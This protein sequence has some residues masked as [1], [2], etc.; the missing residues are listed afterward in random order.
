[1]GIVDVGRI[2][3]DDSPSVIIS[4][5]ITGGLPILADADPEMEWVLLVRFAK[6]RSTSKK[7]AMTFPNL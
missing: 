5:W 1:M 3:S 7:D 4:S 6:I 2:N